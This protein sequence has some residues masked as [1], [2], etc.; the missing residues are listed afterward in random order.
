MPAIFAPSPRLAPRYN[1]LQSEILSHEVQ[2][3]HRPFSHSM[4]PLVRRVGASTLT[5]GLSTPQ[6]TITS[7]SFLSSPRLLSPII[8]NEPP[9]VALVCH[10]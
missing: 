4:P 1:T 3:D 6:Q 8:L 10:I 7:R 2:P 9:Y 5:P